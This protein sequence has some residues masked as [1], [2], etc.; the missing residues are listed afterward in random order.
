MSDKFGF[1]QLEILTTDSTDPAVLYTCPVREAVDVNSVADVVPSAQAKNVQTQISSLIACNS[2]A[3]G[4]QVYVHFTESAS[5]TANDSNILF[6]GIALDI[7][8][9]HILSLGLLMSAGNTVWVSTDTVS[10]VTFTLN[11]IEIS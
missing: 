10:D 8:E 9:T 3:A 2:G 6:K 4:E 1:A 11:Y 7:A 5:D